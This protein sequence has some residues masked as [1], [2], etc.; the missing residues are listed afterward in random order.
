MLGLCDQE[1]IDPRVYL[2]SVADTLFR[3]CHERN[4]RLQPGML[5][6]PKAAQ[7]YNTWLREKRQRGSRADVG[8]KQERSHALVYVQKYAD[9]Y[10]RTKDEEVA[11][12][13]ASRVSKGFSPDNTSE[14]LFAVTQFLHDL[15]PSLPDVIV[16]REGWTL[17]DVLDVVCAVLT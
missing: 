3:F 17:G 8:V 5:I 16:L 4:L 11:Q 1:N 2:Q 13:V 14:Y 9:V 7:R 15:H 6:G 12:R 10:V